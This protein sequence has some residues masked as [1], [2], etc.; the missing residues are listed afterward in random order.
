MLN[1]VK[2][3]CALPGVASFEDE[4]RDFLKIRAAGLADEEMCIR[5][6]DYTRHNKVC[7]KCK[8]LREV[9]DG[10][11]NKREDGYDCA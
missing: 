8:L 4:V 5:D 7:G 1:L 11:N 3:L 2:E 10:H 9:Q 6:S